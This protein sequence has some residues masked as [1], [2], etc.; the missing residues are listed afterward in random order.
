MTDALETVRSLLAAIGNDVGCRHRYEPGGGPSFGLLARLGLLRS[1]DRGVPA[2]AEHGCPLLGRCAYE[3]E[4]AGKGG[5]RSG[6]K[7][8]VT[9]AGRGAV[10]D[11]A[12]LERLVVDDLAALPPLDTLERG[13]RSIFALAND[14]LEADLTAADDGARRPGLSRRELGTA[15]RLLAAAGAIV[16][17]DDGDGV[18]LGPGRPATR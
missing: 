12:L 14:L 13:P 4:F 7:F 5:K 3:A 11:R 15:L 6:R 9:D 16:L 1:I 17:D 8:R 18:R 2:C 10:E